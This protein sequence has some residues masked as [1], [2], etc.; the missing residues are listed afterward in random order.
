MEWA[1]FSPSGINIDRFGSRD[2]IYTTGRFVPWDCQKQTKYP[3]RIV[4]CCILDEVHT[5]DKIKTFK[6]QQIT[7]RTSYEF[8]E[9]YLFFTYCLCIS[10]ILLEKMTT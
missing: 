1:A 7:L 10:V 3:S 8:L 4:P 2:D 5:V 6:Q 9:V